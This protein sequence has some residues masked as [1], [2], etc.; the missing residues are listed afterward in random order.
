MNEGG[1][2]GSSDV[3]KEAV[4]WRRKG[5]SQVIRNGSGEIMK[6]GRLKD[7]ELGEGQ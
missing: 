7:C 6:E 3:A 5:G 1:G 2:R 4:R